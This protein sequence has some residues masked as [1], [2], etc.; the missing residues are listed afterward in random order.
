VPL[1][2]DVGLPNTERMVTTL[3]NPAMVAIKQPVAMMIPRF[4]TVLCT[5]GGGGGGG[6]L[7]AVV[8]E[9]AAAPTESMAAL[10]LSGC[11]TNQT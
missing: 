2:C 5:T 7:G 11:S 8:R 10:A 1:T 6:A 9:G 4:A 3:I